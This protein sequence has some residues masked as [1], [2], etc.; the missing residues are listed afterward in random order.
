[1]SFMHVPVQVI[2]LN[3]VEY[4]AFADILSA[5]QT[6]ALVLAAEGEAPLAALVCPS[7]SLL[8]AGDLPAVV[9]G[10]AGN[11]RSRSLSV[12]ARLSEILEALE[13]LV[14]ATSGLDTPRDYKGWHLDPAR[15]V[16][17][18]PDETSRSLTDT[19][20]RLLACLFDAQGA[21]IGR[22]VLLQRVWGYRPGL[23]T[24]TLETHVYRLRKKIEADPANPAIVLTT[25][26]GYR[27]A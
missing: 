22:D 14:S 13:M 2:A 20:A 1:M 23:D 12:P 4:Q 26:T 7:G 18:A 11:E 10:T 24:H 3:P 9:L 27:L 8:D 19:E 25:D 6:G 16:L 15:L 5:G 21:E 17:R